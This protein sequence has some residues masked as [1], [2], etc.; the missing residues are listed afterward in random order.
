MDREERDQILD[1][2][3]Q[4]GLV[5][6]ALEE[7]SEDAVRPVVWSVAGSDSGG[8]AGMQADIKVFQ[9]MGVHGCS[10]LSS[11]T[12]QNSQGVERVHP[13]PL[14][15]VQAQWRA[16]IDDLPPAAIKVGLPG[17]AAAVRFL[18][19]QFIRLDVPKIIDP[20]GT[21]STGSPLVD[22]ETLELVQTLLVPYADVLTPNLPEAEQL[23]GRS[24]P[25]PDD[26]QEA[27]NELVQRGAGSVVIKGGH[28]EGER[29]HDFWSNGSQYAWLTSPRHDT[30]HT[31]GTGCTFASAL[32]A[33]RA[34][35]YHEL[36]AVVIAKAYV[37]QALAGAYPTGAGPGTL[38]H[39][40]WPLYPA[41]LPALSD[42]GADLPGEAFAPFEMD[43]P[44]L[45]PVVD[46]A[47]WVERLLPLGVTTL[48]IRVKDLEGSARES[49]LASA[50]A[51]AKAAGAHLY[52]NDDWETALRLGAYGVHLGQ[53]DLDGAD[54]AALARAGLRLGVSTHSYTE[55]SRAIAVRPSYVALG[56]L[57][58][59]SSKVMDYPPLG[60]EAFRRMSR[61]VP[62]PVVA[63]GGISLENASDVLDA[64]ADGLA[65]ISA[66]TQ[67]E[68]LD[69]AVAAWRT[70]LA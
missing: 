48:Q 61:A 10:V 47:A 33:A 18:V 37:N 55:L 25:E 30:R 2:I 5:V 15:Q 36:D 62:V 11:V 51:A 66:I 50:I 43:G 54:L 59:T 23:V 26:V 22:A 13:L 14:R 6:Q 63:I 20:V 44:E 46:R 57:F 40:G 24:L 67:A 53:D 9:A 52:V 35:G 17:N 16:L 38:D 64:G 56:T 39:P 45:Y 3:E 7:T 12:A 19:E 1:E 34:L 58:P 31:H 69:A 29:C 41:C 4:Q 42:T 27:A 8:G 21:A 28:R 49:E 32:A 68:D 65:M 60:L 70:V